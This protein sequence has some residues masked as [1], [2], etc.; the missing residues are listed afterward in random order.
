LSGPS[1][2]PWYSVH[3]PE[4][5]ILGQTVPAAGIDSLKVIVIEGLLTFFLVSTVIQVAA[6]GKAEKLAPVAVAIGF[7]LA[8]CILFGGPL[9]GGS[10]NPARTLG[11]GLVSGDTRE[12]FA[13]LIGIFGGGALAGLVHT[14]LFPE[15][16]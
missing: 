13:Y 1:W 9:T 15:H 2:L 5:I 16:D 14:T 10:L 4:T 3:L 6:F 11:P 8:A 12:I 7:T